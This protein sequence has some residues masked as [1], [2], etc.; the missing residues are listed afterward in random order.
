MKILKI[1]GITALMA[2]SLSL[3]GV[4][5]AN[6]YVYPYAQQPYYAPQPYYGHHPDPRW[7]AER[8]RERRWRERERR[9]EWERHHYRV[10]RPYHW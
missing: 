4:A 10:D 5:Q 9:L 1:L 3:S 7:V 6:P 2:A 8:E